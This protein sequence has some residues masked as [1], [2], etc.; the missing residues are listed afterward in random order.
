MSKNKY[1]LGMDF[2]TSGVRGIVINEEEKIIE[3]IKYS[4]DYNFNNPQIWQENLYE[5]LQNIS[6]EIKIICNCSTE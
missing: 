6:A 1:Y 5:I 4:F 3:E 2:G